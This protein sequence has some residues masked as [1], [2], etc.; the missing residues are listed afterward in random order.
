MNYELSID[1][2]LNGK[3]MNKDLFQNRNLLKIYL[4]LF[5]L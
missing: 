1:A 5:L 3:S 4:L 2:V